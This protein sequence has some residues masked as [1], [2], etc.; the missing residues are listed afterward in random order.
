VLTQFDVEPTPDEKG[1]SGI[2][3]TCLA[4]A[5]ALLPTGPSRGSLRL[6]SRP[7]TA[8]AAT[9]LPRLIDYLGH[10]VGSTSAWECPVNGV[11]T[12]ELTID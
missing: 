5:I 9:A 12:L 2:P 7:S 8:A 1:I 11:G 4:A 10:S 3:V 6:A